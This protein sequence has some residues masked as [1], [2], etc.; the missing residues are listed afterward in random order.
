MKINYEKIKGK[1]IITRDHYNTHVLLL[2]F[3]YD[4]K[5]PITEEHIYSENRVLYDQWCNLAD[6]IRN[7]QYQFRENFA[8]ALDSELSEGCIYGDV[9]TLRELGYEPI[10]LTDS[11]DELPNM[12]EILGVTPNQTLEEC[13]LIERDMYSPHRVT[14]DGV[15]R[16]HNDGCLNVSEVLDL[17]RKVGYITDDENKLYDLFNLSPNDFFKISGRTYDG[18]SSENNLS[19]L[20]QACKTN[21]GLIYDLVNNPSEII[22]IKTLEETPTKKGL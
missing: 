17:F 16:A 13:G 8:I 10:S 18:F 6:K 4:G 9:N 3:V 11:L 22:K 7:S 15:I 12:C 21:T 19:E 14:L 20:I 5:L 2:A 1:A